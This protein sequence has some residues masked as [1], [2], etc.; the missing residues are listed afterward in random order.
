MQLMSRQ[1][2]TQVMCRGEPIPVAR[3]LSTYVTPSGTV[4]VQLAMYPPD[5]SPARPVYRVF[6]AQTA[7]DLSVK[8]AESGPELCFTVTPQPVTAGGP[9]LVIPIAPGAVGPHIARD[10]LKKDYRE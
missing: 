1:D 8:L 6:E 5:D 7:D 3:H 10:D 2:S 4:L 9:A